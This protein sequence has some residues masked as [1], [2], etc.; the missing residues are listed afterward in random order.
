MTVESDKNKSG[1]FNVTGPS[2]TFPRDFLVIDEDDLRV[3]RVRDGVETDLTTGVG[4]T[5]IGSPD[6]TVV[7]SS[8]IAAGDQVYLLRAV[9]NLQRSDYNS[10]GRVRTEQVEVDL[11][12]ATMQIQDLAE[13]QSRSLMVPVSSELSGEEA[14]QAVLDAPRYAGDALAAAGQAASYAAQAGA[15]ADR[16]AEWGPAILSS[17]AAL[18]ASSD[19]FAPGSVMM[20]RREALSYQVAPASAT[21]HHMTTAGGVKLYEL[22]PKFTTRQRLGQAVQRGAL[23]QGAQVEAGGVRF[24]VD[25]AAT[26]MDS[27]LWAAGISGLR[28]DSPR[29]V[30]FGTFFKTDQARADLYTTQ[31]PRSLFQV[32]GAPIARGASQGM[33]GFDPSMHWDRDRKRFSIHV[34]QGGT[35]FDVTEYRS[36]DL[37]TW[38][39]FYRNLG[40][41]RV[42][43]DSTPVAGGTVPASIVWWM[44]LHEQGG[45]L[46]GIS[47]IRMF[48]DFVDVNGRTIPNMQLH[49]SRVNDRDAMTFDAP[50]K[51][52]FPDQVCRIG[53]FPVWDGVKWVAFCKNDFSKNIE[54]WHSGSLLGP[55]TFQYTLDYAQDV[56]GCCVVPEYYYPLGS[57]S[58]SRR[59]HLLTD[60]YWSGNYWHKVSTDLV[61]WTDEV[62][63]AT[64]ANIRHGNL[65]NF[66]YEQEAA[67]VIERAIAYYGA[68]SGQRPRRWVE[69]ADGVN[70]IHPEEDTTYFVTGTNAATVNILFPAART[71]KFMVKSD[72]FR[73]AI[74]INHGTF[75]R[76]RNGVSEIIGGTGARTVFSLEY[77]G[78]AYSVPGQRRDALD[79]WV[80]FGDSNT[81]R[82]L[83]WAWRLGPQKAKRFYNFAVG[84]ATLVGN[85]A[86][87]TM[88]A[89]MA[90]AA[91]PVLQSAD[92]VTFMFGTNDFSQSLPLGALGDITTA[93]FYGALRAAMAQ[94][95]TACPSARIVFMTPIYR[96]TGDTDQNAYRDA[97]KAFCAF[98]HVECLDVHNL[99]GLNAFNHGT[100]YE[101]GLHPNA[102]GYRKVANSIAPYL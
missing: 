59:W 4:H 21:D 42:R 60:A 13:R 17:R 70:D 2:G 98:H 31:D 32:N 45:E 58:L 75:F 18:V 74:I 30:Y 76:A 20:V 81:A 93:T 66:A 95:T 37:I 64:T 36:N 8:G 33:F 67:Q 90:T 26:G 61:T 7:V 23:A 1:P 85:S 40:V 53:F 83:S 12:R 94:C 91:G 69:L 52:D 65:Y 63:V 47:L 14:M 22:G 44:G 82:E 34:F 54:C 50:V 100:L 24:T 79:V 38:Q 89:Q 87:N 96:L 55:W 101:D 71:T 97:I 49:V 46:Y 10:Q 73:A 72:S 35:E 29:N 11:D 41:T 9:P 3:I 25:S 102:L 56:E 80:S 86:G 5:G 84:G 92:L 27:A 88:A 48:A 6:G 57:T 77:D 28:A 51:M 16:V 39:A 19:P 78:E 68:G 43:S 62:P 15:A 99:C